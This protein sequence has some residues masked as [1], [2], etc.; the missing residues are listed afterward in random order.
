ML[1]G[2]EF[3]IEE[4]SW[5]VRVFYIIG[6]IPIEYIIDKLQDIGC[7]EED[8]DKVYEN[9]YKND[10]NRGVTYSNPITHESIIIIG[11]SSCPAEFQNSFDHEKH[12]LATHIAKDFNIDPYGEELAYLVGRIGLEM[13]PVAKRFLCEHCRE[14]MK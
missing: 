11:D 4:Y 12:H 8:L 7:S 14:K 13:F 9:L 6:S 2:Q 3:N 10:K 5:N 1:L